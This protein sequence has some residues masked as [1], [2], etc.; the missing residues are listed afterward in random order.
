MTVAAGSRQLADLTRGMVLA[1]NRRADASA[2]LAAGGRPI[3]EAAVVLRA[4]TRA[5]HLVAPVE[6]Q[7]HGR[8][9]L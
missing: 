6:D 5:A 8:R 7:L 9:P 2:E 3:F 4:N 1:F